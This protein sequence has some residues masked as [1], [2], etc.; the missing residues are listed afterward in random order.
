[1]APVSYLQAFL[2]AEPRPLHLLLDCHSSRA[3]L[4]L[5]ARSVSHSACWRCLNAMHCSMM[6]MR[7]CVAA[8]YSIILELGKQ[9]LAER[10]HRDGWQPSGHESMCAAR[11]L[12][13]A[14][15]HLHDRGVLHR[16]INPSNV[17][18]GE[19][20]S[21]WS[22]EI[23]HL[24]AFDHGHCN[25]LVSGLISPRTSVICRGGWHSQAGGLQHCPV[26]R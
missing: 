21:F 13:A 23:I 20:S 11:Q 25:S 1:M 7:L 9:Q 15:C 16:D 24:R 10:I 12:A 3:D 17:L 22:L 4:D 26:C 19:P 6:L 14:M 18:F 2:S 8:D 5:V